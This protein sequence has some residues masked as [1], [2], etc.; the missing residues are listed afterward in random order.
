VTD[1]RRYLKTGGLLV[2]SEITWL[3]VSRPADLAAHED[4]GQPQPIFFLTIRPDSCIVLSVSDSAYN[5][6]NFLLSRYVQF[7]DIL[8]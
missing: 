5:L 2:V 6:L 1:W 3:T 4:E 7:H 8:L